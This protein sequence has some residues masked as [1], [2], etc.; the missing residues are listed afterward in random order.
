MLRGKN[1]RKGEGCMDEIKIYVLIGSSVIIHIFF[2]L[3]VGEND[4]KLHIFLLSDIGAVISITVIFFVLS[5]AYTIMN[6]MKIKFNELN[7]KHDHID[8]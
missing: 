8:K 7:N 2:M 1:D 5:T 3:W 4:Q 6:F